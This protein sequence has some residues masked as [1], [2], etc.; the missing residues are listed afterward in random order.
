MLYLS[1]ILNSK[2]KDSSDKV[3]GQLKD[4]LIKSKAGEYSPLD[5]LL[6]KGRKGEEFFVPYE[7]V[8]NLS[9]NELT[10]KSL[11]ENI[12]ISEPEGAFAYLV[13]DVLDQQIV[14]VEGARVVRVNDL[15]LGLF[16]N[17]MCVLG[18]DVS[19]RGILRRL[20]LKG[21]DLFNLLPVRLIDWRKT[22]RVR[23]VLK[24]DTISDDLTRLHPADLANIV[25][26]LTVRQGAKLVKNLDT[27]IAAAIV[28]E[29]DPTAQKMLVNY[30][31]P[32]KAAKIIE[33]MSADEIADLMQMLSKSD[34]KHLL[35]YLKNGKLKKVE[36]L[37]EYENNTAGGLMTTDYV[38][39]RQE[40]TVEMAIEEIKKM[41]PTMRSMLYVY[42]TDEDGVFKGAV[43]LRRLLT[44]N[45]KQTLG[46]LIKRLPPASTLHVHQKIN[47]IIKVMTK[48][49]LYTAAVL[50]E[51]K[52]LVG[53]VTID[54][55]MRIIM[56]NA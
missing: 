26:E 49:N 23:G 22:Q 16:E 19:F 32:E 41:S 31:G 35:S 9:K 1:Q 18:I 3:I 46:A 47:S 24:L 12:T 44:A 54:D 20:G 28:E 5:F 48:Y 29:M 30:L 6:V 21:L 34:A 7:Y 27:A 17:K 10:L 50:D 45:K 11:F 39:G 53:M 43:S 56:P 40:W 42:V 13:R 37:I 25:E 36:K 55:I 8:E 33:K 15:K 2:I 4:I 52:K 51:N 38:S 14:D